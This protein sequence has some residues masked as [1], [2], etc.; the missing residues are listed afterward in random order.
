[1]TNLPQPPV[2][3]A[4]SVTFF[5]QFQAS[6]QNAPVTAEFAVFVDVVQ[7]DITGVPAGSFI[8]LFFDGQLSA[9]A[10]GS[11]AT[12][13]MVHQVPS[14]NPNLPL[15]GI[16][17]QDVTEGGFAS[18][19]HVNFQRIDK[20][21]AEDRTYIVQVQ[22]GGGA[23]PV[24]VENPPAGLPML[25][26][27][28]FSPATPGGTMMIH[29]NGPTAGLPAATT[30][31]LFSGN[32]PSTA[33]TENLASYRA[34]RNSTISRIRISIPSNTLDGSTTVTIRV[35]GVA[36]AITAVIPAGDTTDVDIAATA[37]V[38]DGQDVSV[39]AATGG[40]TGAIRLVVS[41]EIG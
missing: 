4:G 11:T 12:L 24:R 27:Y 7:L 9:G 18:I 16:I 3:G 33:V 10:A 19:S 14:G 28:V 20:L 25:V 36:T 21:G 29:G 41:Y 34:T 15:G 6:L 35:A 17:R 8:W 38:G 31:Y 37:S 1:M 32:V 13:Q 2:P 39:E 30:A 5:K 22:L 40:T 23:G 26:A